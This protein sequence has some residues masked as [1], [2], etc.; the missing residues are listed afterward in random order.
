[1]VSTSPV[2]SWVV[3]VVG[4]IM[5]YCKGQK[6]FQSSIAA[7]LKIR[8]LNI[9]AYDCMT[10][11]VWLVLVACWYEKNRPASTT[12]MCMVDREDDGLIT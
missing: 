6:A 2:A 5:Q 9:P 1:V 11:I 4:F 10:L 3:V 12:I 7:Y 8:Q